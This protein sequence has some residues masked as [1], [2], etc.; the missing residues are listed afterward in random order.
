MTR[1]DG[2]AQSR[3][4]GIPGATPAPALSGRWL[5]WWWVKRLAATFIFAV[6][7]GV[8]GGVATFYCYFIGSWVG[9]PL[10]FIAGGFLGWRTP[11]RDVTLVLAG[12]VSTIYFIT[13]LTRAFQWP[14]SFGDIGAAVAGSLAAPLVYMLCRYIPSLWRYYMA[15]VSAWILSLVWL[16][17]FVRWLNSQGS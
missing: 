2:G 6:I 7:G 10:G 12:T 5:V 17:T 16:L 13:A 1:W 11:P 3:I 14:V 8:T 4:D 9:A 15:V